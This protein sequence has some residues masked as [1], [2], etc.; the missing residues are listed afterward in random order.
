MT[1]FM[2][3]V[4]PS[5]MTLRRRVLLRHFWA[6]LFVLLIRA[7]LIGAKILLFYLPL[8]LFPLV[9]NGSPLETSKFT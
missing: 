3:H 2:N 9:L 6:N 8:F 1:I 7:I 4:N 5:L